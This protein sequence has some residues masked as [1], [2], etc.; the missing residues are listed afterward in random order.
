[1]VIYVAPAIV[2]S[3]ATDWLMRLVVDVPAVTALY[4]QQSVGSQ[5]ALSIAYDVH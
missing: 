4:G 1:V 3:P 2:V 5:V